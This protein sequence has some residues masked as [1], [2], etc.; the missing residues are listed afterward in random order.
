MGDP[1]QPKSY[2]DP[3]PPKQDYGQKP[4]EGGD[5]PTPPD[6]P[7]DDGYG[8][9]KPPRDCG[10]PEPPENPCKEGVYPVPPPPPENCDKRPFDVEIQGL[11]DDANKEDRETKKEELAKYK[12]LSDDIWKAEKDY[13]K[14][15]ESLVRQ[16]QASE[17]YTDDLKASLDLKLTA[18]EKK[19]IAEIVYCA[20]NVEELKKA[21]QDARDQLPELQS[22]LAV[23]QNAFDDQDTEYKAALTKYQ[24]AQKALDE[25]ESLSSKAVD[26]KKYRGAWFLNQYEECPSL[27]EPP[28]PCKFNEWLE[29]IGKKEIAASEKL[30][31]AK[32]TLDQKT[33]DVQKKKKEYEDAK[34][35]R[36]E[37]ILKA[38]AADPFPVPPPPK[39]TTSP[40]GG[41][42]PKAD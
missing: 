25:L 34:A 3:E 27:E 5:T 4:P 35:K 30:R 6:T 36:R 7:P 23:A 16:E 20:P 29:A 10:Q 32:V 13:A 12:K 14:E 8:E 21:W 15:Y 9:P 38:I 11:E 40:E 26:A 2:N 17:T 39:D 1:Q 41:T 37:N 24:T 28:I 22:L 18:S 33:A 19:R 42:E 31:Q